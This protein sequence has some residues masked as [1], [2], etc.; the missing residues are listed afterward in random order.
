MSELVEKD[1]MKYELEEYKIKV[2]VI[3]KVALSHLGKRQQERHF[4]PGWTRVSCN[5]RCGNVLPNVVPL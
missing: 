1:T 2:R 5:P 4:V 3:N